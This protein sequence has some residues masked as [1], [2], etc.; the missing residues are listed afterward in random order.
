MKQLKEE[1]D[2]AVSEN[3]ELIESQTEDLVEEPKGKVLHIKNG[4]KGV[5]F[6]GVLVQLSQYADIEHTLT[7]IDRVKQYVIQVPLQYQKALDEGTYFINQNQTTGVMW[8][9][10]MEVRESGRWGFVDNLPI[11]EQNLVQGNPMRDISINFY[12]LALQKQIASIADAVERTYKVV[13]RIEHGQMDDRIALLYSGREQIQLAMTLKDS[14]AR[15]QAMALGRKSLID[16]K[17]QL[18]MTLKRR[19]EEFE[20]IPEGWFAQR[21]LAFRHKGIFDQRDDE[22]QEMQDYYELYF[23]ST[24]L[25]AASYIATDEIEAAKK[26]YGDSIEFI[27]S[28]RFGNAQTIKF[29]HKPKEI[30]DQFV[31]HPVAYIEAEQEDAEGGAKEFDYMIIEATGEELLEVFGDGNEI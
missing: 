31:Y 21:W 12:N 23:E 7:H 16:A 4:Q 11:A 14:D 15:K 5:D 17:Y 13:E 28:I 8:P 20:P 24:K 3:S 19:I 18:G 26:A 10:L 30:Q 29:V 27:K 6:R 2:L 9:S 1:S 25:L 22:F